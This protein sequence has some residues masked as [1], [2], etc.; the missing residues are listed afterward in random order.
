MTPRGL[1][2]RHGDNTTIQDDPKA[3]ATDNDEVIIPHAADQNIQLEELHGATD[4]RIQPVNIKNSAKVSNSQIHK[5]FRTSTRQ[6]KTPY[7]T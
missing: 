6:K 4:G 2:L 3:A 5:V 1:T 7:K